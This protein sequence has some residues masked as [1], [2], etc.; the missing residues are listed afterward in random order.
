[1]EIVCEQMT[2]QPNDLLNRAFSDLVGNSVDFIGI[3]DNEGRILFLNPAAR[4]LSALTEQDDLS[5]AHIHD[6][7]PEWSIGSFIRDGNL[8]DPSN[9]NI[10]HET[11]LRTADEN[12]I[13]V[14]LSVTAHLAGDYLVDHF[15]ISARDM[16]AQKRLQTN[17]ETL[18]SRLVDLCRTRTVG[19]IAVGLAHNLNDSLI[20]ISRNVSVVL[21]VTAEET[22]ERHCLHRAVEAINSARSTVQRIVEAGETRTSTLDHV[23]LPSVI[24]DAV[25]LARASLPVNIIVRQELTPKPVIVSVD[26]IQ[27]HQIVMNLIINARDSMI[28]AGG[29]IEVSLESIEINEHKNRRG[30]PIE[31]C[32]WA[33]MRIT[34]SGA[35]FDP[36]NMARIFSPHPADKA[37]L[38]DAAL[39]LAVV[40]KIVEECG[41][42][43]TIHNRLGRG[44]SYHVFLPQY[45][46][47]A[48]N[49]CS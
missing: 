36:D 4:R 17:W 32:R 46:E 14:K 23:S 1:M 20:R 3:A 44:T 10:Q 35:G 27:I 48:P 2:N 49:Y 34:D 18:E 8:V 37:K 30:E 7:F 38:D 41:G 29:V 28:H 39:N 16:S 13:P 47:S 43:L 40:N 21:D 22:N 45:V 19:K 24:K 15:I 31:R 9:V 5:K 25:M 33:R 42:A 12:N 6:F 11:V 26:P